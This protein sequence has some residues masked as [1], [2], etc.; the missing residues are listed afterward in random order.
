MENESPRESGIGYRVSPYFSIFHFPLSI[1]L[2]GFIILAPFTAWMAITG[3]LRPPID[4]LLVALALGAPGLLLTL[5]NRPRLLMPDEED[6]LLVALAGVMWLSWYVM[7]SHT[8]KSLNHTISF[9]FV[10]SCYLILFKALWR[11]ARLS[12]EDLFRAAF[13]MVVLGNGIV[14]VEWLL[15]NLL[16]VEIRHYFIWSD[17]VTNMTFYDQFFFLSVG[18]TAE[19][20]SLMAYNLNALFPLAWYYVRQQPRIRHWASALVGLHV[21]GMLATASSGGIGFFAIGFVVS[22][23]LELKRS[24]VLQLAVAVLSTVVL[25]G[26]TYLLLPGDAQD[27][28]EKFALNVTSKMVFNQRS[29]NMRVE[30][31]QHG[32][33]D[34]LSSPWLGHGPAYGHEAYQMFGYQSYYFKLLAEGGVFAFG[35]MVAFL[36]VIAVKIW[37]IRQPLRRFLLMSFIASTLHWAIADCYYHVSFWVVIA[38]V[39]LIH[40]DRAATRPRLV[41]STSLI[42]SV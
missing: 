26:V 35:L 12:V 23:L 31:W 18:G 22:G 17:A 41:Q 15:I 16:D 39:Q 14:V 28:A 1:F 9:T 30:A 21:W 2:K 38:A 25:V 8:G 6:W 7:G 13:Y 42:G 19:E 36:V 40:Q 32:V 11:Q 33:Q 27:K 10:Y 20:P 34:F 24:R 4:C 3:W 37:R 29:A 5:V